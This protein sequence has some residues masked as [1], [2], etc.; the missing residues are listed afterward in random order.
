MGFCRIARKSCCFFQGICHR[1]MI[2]AHRG[3]ARRRWYPPCAE[4]RAFFE[5]QWQ[6]IRDRSGG[7]RHDCGTS[8]HLKDKEMEARC[9]VSGFFLKTEAAYVK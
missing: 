2:A 5:K 8:R 7:S 4:Y 3:M 1:G 6:N 9:L